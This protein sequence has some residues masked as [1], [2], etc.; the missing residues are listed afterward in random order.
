MM[1]YRFICAA[2]A[3]LVVVPGVSPAQTEKVDSLALATIKEEGLQRSEVMDLLGALSDVYGPRLSW[4]PEYRR[5]AEWVV[6][7][8]KGWG[9]DRVGFDN[10]PPVGKGWTLKNFSAMVT[11]PVPYPV[12]AY[13]MAWSQG[14]KEKE[15]E[16]VL[17]DV[18]RPEDFEKYK[19]TLKG[20]F[21]LL[22]DEIPVRAHFAP[23]AERLADSL[24]LRMANADA[25]G[26]RGR[27]GAAPPEIRAGESRFDADR[28]QAGESR[29]RYGGVAG[30]I[31]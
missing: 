17:L 11:V 6:R 15:A 16:V 9:I 5:G 22:G 13:P 21:V 18:K 25:A 19:G 7:K 14:L 10:Y 8:L 2:L 3:L 29:G 31:R 27:Q 30:E 24:L 23:Q 1:H 12:I 4:S 20:K 28:V 26:G